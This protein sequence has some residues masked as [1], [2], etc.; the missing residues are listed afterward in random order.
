MNR[1]DERF[2]FLKKNNRK[3]LIPYICGGDP[4]L[5][6]TE[7]LVCLLD[8]AGADIIEL[9]IPY[10]DPL[11][12]GPVIQAAGL[13]AFA[14]GFR[15]DRFFD[16]V[17]KIRKKSN[18]PLVCMVYFSSII[19]YGTEK[20]VENCKRAD[21]DGLIVP[22]LPYEEYDE[23]VPCLEGSGICLIPLVA[24]TS[25][26]RIKMLTENSSGFIYCV[27]SLGVT[28]ERESFDTR[29]ED[30]VKSVKE[31]TDTPAC[32]GFGVSCREDVEHFNSFADGVIV[33]S[34]LVRRIH[35]NINDPDKVKDFIR[36]LKG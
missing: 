18:V 30:F 8:E 29:I 1:I 25:G 35:E 4:S 21:I 14:N 7:R 12:D 10:S 19:G 3:A 33:G 22:D 26:E 2:A 17:V 23:L 32:I 20:F 27:S 31:V 24:L 36:E 6:M 16:T 11:A 28:G 13:R 5:D 9:G 15:I 34:A